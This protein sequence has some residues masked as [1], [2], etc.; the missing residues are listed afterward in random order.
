[1]TQFSDQRPVDDNTAE[2]TPPNRWAE[3]KRL[4]AKA[5]RIRLE[6]MWRSP[7]ERVTLETVANQL[8]VFARGA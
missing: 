1:M 3:R 2:A 5:Q 4:L 7:G 8:E 6:A